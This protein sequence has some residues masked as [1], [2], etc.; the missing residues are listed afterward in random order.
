MSATLLRQIQVVDPGGPAHGTE[1]DLLVQDGKIARVGQR[2][3]KGTAK[4][5]KVPGLHASPG[6]VDLQA[7]FRD[8]GEEYKQGLLN[9]LDAAAAGGFTAVAVLP[10]TQPVIDARAGI[11][12]LLRKGAGHAVRVLPIGALT[13]GLQGQQLAELFDLKQ[14]GAV[15]F[16]GGDEGEAAEQ[17]AISLPWLRRCRS[18]GSARSVP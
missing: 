5:I 2:I 8:P 18:P 13:K 9:G 12:H 1:V 4:E 3:P 17:G 16:A 6:W 11:E 15:A 7:H 14:A 10:S